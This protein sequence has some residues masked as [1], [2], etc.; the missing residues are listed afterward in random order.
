M[1]FIR[2]F[3]VYLFVFPHAN[4][5]TKPFTEEQE[6][7][8]SAVYRETLAL[9]EFMDRHIPTYSKAIRSCEQPRRPFSAYLSGLKE[10]RNDLL[11]SISNLPGVE[12]RELDNQLRQKLGITLDTL[13][14][15]RL[16][17]IATLREKGLLSTDSQFRLVYGRVDQIWDDPNHSQEAVELQALLTAYENK[18]RSKLE[19]RSTRK[20]SA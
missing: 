17:K 20:G 15:K 4:S 1:N 10:A 2:H 9:A 18:V 8:W 5:M 16:A 12:L 19:R 7:A 3:G 6:Q 11:E 13:Q 14:G